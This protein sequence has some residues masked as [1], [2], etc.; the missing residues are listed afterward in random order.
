[1]H[2]VSSPVRHALSEVRNKL[3]QAAYTDGGVEW[4]KLFEKSA[5]GPRSELNWE[6]FYKFIR[7]KAKLASPNPFCTHT[8]NLQ[9]KD[10][11][12]LSDDALREVF[13]TVDATNPF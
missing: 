4:A 8:H 11:F 5:L 10:E 2:I 9:Q 6:Q 12:V 1:M 3:R 13:M 7:T